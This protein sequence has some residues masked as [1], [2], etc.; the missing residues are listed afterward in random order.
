MTTS[1]YL[2]RPNSETDT[3]VYARISYNGNQVKYY[4]PEKI[5]PKYWSTKTKRAKQN[6]K[7]AHYREFNLHLDNMKNTI[8]NVFR[9]YQN[10][11]ETIPHPEVLKELLDAKI[12]NKV[13]ETEKS[14]FDFFEELIQRSENGTRTNPK[15]NKPLAKKTCEVYRT[16]KRHLTE[17][18]IAQNKKVNF[19]NINFTF[20]DKYTAYL[21][22]KSF[23]NNYVGKH[24]KVI[25]TVLNEAKERGIE[26]NPDYQSNKFK[27]FD[28]EVDSIYLTENEISQIE[29]LDLS[30]NTRL[31]V[32][33]DLFLIGCKTGLR[34]S[35][36]SDLKPENFTKDGFLERKQSKTRDNVVI[37]IHPKVK[38]ILA[39]YNG[40][41]PTT[42][43]NQKT[44]DYLKE[45]GKMIKDLHC[46]VT[47]TRSKG[48]LEITKN[49][50]K[51]QCIGTHTAR[52]S[53]ATIEYL[54]GTPTQTIM[55]ITGHKTEKAF[56][57]YIKLSSREHAKVLLSS[58]NKRL[59][60]NG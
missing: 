26:V 13:S 2:K 39:K 45:I 47:K 54:F 21:L 1:F 9:K 59:A 8:E 16:I 24:I 23:S 4:L 36:Y 46:P 28:E 27:A 51:Y 5:N 44:N 34:Y 57:K 48:G 40:T 22:K 52:R 20:Y 50:L 32:V 3:S 49:L 19:R 25:K 14:F 38:E 37:P 58:M 6:L 41:L 30:K 15:T 55:Q 12:K 35:D 18:S 42:I 43:S 11:T 7:F 53:F 33:R 10:D 31:E 60:A 56:M 29:D 17:F